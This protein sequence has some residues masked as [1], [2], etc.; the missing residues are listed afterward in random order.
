MY[1]NEHRPKPPYALI[2]IL[3]VLILSDLGFIVAMG[4]SILG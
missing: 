4:S 3:A 1:E 2:A